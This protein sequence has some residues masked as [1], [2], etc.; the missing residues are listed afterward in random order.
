VKL[1][2]PRVELVVQERR[3][4]LRE[5]VQDAIQESKR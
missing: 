3:A 5:L 4:R 1:A 2:R